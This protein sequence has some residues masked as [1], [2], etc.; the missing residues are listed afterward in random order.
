MLCFSFKKQKMTLE[1]NSELRC[2]IIFKSPSIEDPLKALYWEKYVKL[3]I[4]V[5]Q[6]QIA[7]S[8]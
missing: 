1:D 5:A 7:S 2:L 4:I 8:K 6:K 3:M